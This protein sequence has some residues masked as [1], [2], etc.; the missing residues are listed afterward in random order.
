LAF[1]SAYALKRLPGVD[2]KLHAS[3][4]QVGVS[5]QLLCRAGTGRETR[6]AGWRHL[7]ALL[8]ALCV[9]LSNFAAVY[10]LAHH[11]GHG[12]WREIARNPLIVATV[13]GLAR[14]RA[15]TAARGADRPTLGRIGQAA[16]PL[17]LMAVGAGLK[18]GGLW[19]GPGLA[20]GLLGIRHVL[21]PIAALVLVHLLG[22]PDA[23]RT[24]V[25]AFAAM[26]TASSAYVLAV[27]MGGNGPFVAGLVTVST[28]LGMASIP[29]WLAVMRAL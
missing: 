23:Q 19:A 4:A 11:G 18:L 28:L 12:F 8:V 13:G 24:I 6:R 1:A 29:A 25:I 7:D 17:G 26:P 16:L 14:Q 27:R 22:V 3:G 20:A 5:L 10:P 9:P 15:R 21:M 2:P